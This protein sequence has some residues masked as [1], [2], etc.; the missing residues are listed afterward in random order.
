[1][2]AQELIDA[3]RRLGI[4]MDEVAADATGGMPIVNVWTDE[5][6][7]RYPLASVVWPHPD[8]PEFN[9]YSW[10]NQYQY[11][12]AADATA[13]Q[14]AEAVQSTLEALKEARQ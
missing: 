12:V 10:G 7:E 13:E 3:G 1:M 6:G 5:P 9:N 11:A 8:K 2:K 14:L 4:R